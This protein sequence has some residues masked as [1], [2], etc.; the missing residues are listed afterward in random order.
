MLPLTMDDQAVIYRAGPDNWAAIY[1]M[2]KLFHLFVAVSIVGAIIL[3]PTYA[4][5]NV[6]NKGLNLL[7][8]GNVGDNQTARLWGT[9][10]LSWLFIGRCS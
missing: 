1:Y 10:I 3:F 6:G 5:G 2:R 4:T 7:T 9:L 8:I